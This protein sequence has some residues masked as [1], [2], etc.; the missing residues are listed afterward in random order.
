MQRFPVDDG[1]HMP[2]QG[3]AAG[4]L[5]RI[6]DVARRLKASALKGNARPQLM[7]KNIGLLRW[8][9]SEP[10]SCI[11]HRA[12]LDLGARVV[13]V[14]LGELLRPLENELPAIARMLGRLYDAVDCDE[15]PAGVAESIARHAGIPVYSGLDGPEHPMRALADL[16]SICEHRAREDG[17]AT[18]LFAGDAFTQRGDAFVRLAE[19][20]G[21]GLTITASSPQAADDAAFLVD[22]TDPVHWTLHAPAGPID[23]AER[24]E[25]YRYVVQAILI[26]TLIGS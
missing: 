19:L 13:K 8:A 16:M 10:E 17:G 5:C 25:N 4:E 1:P 20:L 18:V 7:D 6:F 21:I 3:L 12:G 24:D 15:M 14:R 9:P 2:S 11:V 26:S 23:E 22:A